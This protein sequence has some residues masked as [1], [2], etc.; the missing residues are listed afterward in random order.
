MFVW[1]GVCIGEEAQKDKKRFKFKKGKKKADEVG[2]AS[3]C[4][5][6]WVCA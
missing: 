1:V 2:A 3:V 6:G 5:C 4:L